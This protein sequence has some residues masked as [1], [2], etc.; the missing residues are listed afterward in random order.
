MEQE[1]LERKRAEN[2]A[3]AANEAKS[4]FLANMSHEM[5]TPLNAILG[6]SQLMARSTTLSSE[7]QAKISIINRSGEHLLNMINNVLDMSK[8]EIGRVTVNC[9]YF[10]LYNLLNDLRDMFH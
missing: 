2:A 8:I 10:N 7:H 5:R 9:T 4:K 3:Q 1:I 6:F